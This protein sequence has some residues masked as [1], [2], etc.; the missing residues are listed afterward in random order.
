MIDNSKDVKNLVW[1]AEVFFW[2]IFT[3]LICIG[4]NLILILIYIIL[5]CLGHESIFSRDVAKKVPGVQ[6]YISGLSR[7]QKVQDWEGAGSCAICMEDFK[8]DGD[9]VAELGCSSKHIFHTKC[10]QG[11]IKK[12]KTCPLCREEIPEL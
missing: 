9:F 5:A 12:S 8:Q 10:L 1:T 7:A 3:S 2:I 6:N 4:A 11:W